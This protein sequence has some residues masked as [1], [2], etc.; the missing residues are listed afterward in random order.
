MLTSETQCSTNDTAWER[1]RLARLRKNG[2]FWCYLTLCLCLPQINPQ[3]IIPQ[4]QPESIR[5]TRTRVNERYRHARWRL[6]EG[7]K[8]EETQEKEAET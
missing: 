6:P 4:N 3:G 8:T 7:K 2:S 1:E 5:S